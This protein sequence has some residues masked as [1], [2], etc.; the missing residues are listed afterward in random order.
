M[1]HDV[2]VCPSV[3]LLQKTP[4]SLVTCHATGFYPDTALMFWRKDGEELHE[5][6]EKGEILPN[7]D[8][9]FQMSVGLNVSSV[10]GEDWRKYDSVFQFSGLKD[11]ITTKLDRALIRTNQ[12]SSFGLYIG[13]AIG[14]VLM[15]LAV[16]VCAVVFVTRRRNSSGL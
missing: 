3:S 9:T 14:A 8:G 10:T 7:N 12:G 16:V 6:V 1:Q 2:T 4:F 11:S 15:L 13:I 5:G